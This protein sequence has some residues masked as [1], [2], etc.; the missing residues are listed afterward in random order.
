MNVPNEAWSLTTLNQ[1][2][3]VNINNLFYFYNPKVCIIY[4]ND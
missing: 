2:Y 4:N 1:D 3:K